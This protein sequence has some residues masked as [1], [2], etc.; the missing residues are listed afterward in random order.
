MVSV[1]RSQVNGFHKLLVSK[2]LPMAPTL[3]LVK[4]LLVP[5]PGAQSHPQHSQ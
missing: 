1:Q 2:S 4:H 3:T 5:V